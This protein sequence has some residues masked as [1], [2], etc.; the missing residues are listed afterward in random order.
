MFFEENKCK[1]SLVTDITVFKIDMMVIL[2]FNN[3][4]MYSLA[5]T[6]IENNK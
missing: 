6:I 5:F 3:N 2:R 1:F 4:Y